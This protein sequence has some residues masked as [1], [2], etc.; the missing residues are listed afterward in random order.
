MVE[1]R[2]AAVLAP[3]EVHLPAGLTRL[4]FVLFVHF[5]VGLSPLRSCHGS[6]A[7]RTR[8]AHRALLQLRAAPSCV[9]QQVWQLQC[10]TPTLGDSRW[11]LLGISCG[12]GGHHGEL[13]PGEPCRGCALLQ[14]WVWPRSAAFKAVHRLLVDAWVGQ[15]V[16]VGSAAF[17][18]PSPVLLRGTRPQMNVRD[19]CRQC[20]FA[21]WRYRTNTSLGV[22]PVGSGPGVS[23]QVCSALCTCEGLEARAGWV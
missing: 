4:S 7:H 18:V 19:V 10:Q 5:Q 2:G 11:H 21:L 13:Q 12:W 23:L 20:C 14:R 17:V 1:A 6:A 16:P 3:G 8:R 9:F 22:H 15:C